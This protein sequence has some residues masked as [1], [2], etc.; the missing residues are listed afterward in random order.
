MKMNISMWKKSH[1]A[2]AAAL[3]ALHDKQESQNQFL[4]S[5]NRWVFCLFS[6]LENL[7]KSN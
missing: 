5:G 3:K 6:Y 2:A 1:T 7:L 4:L